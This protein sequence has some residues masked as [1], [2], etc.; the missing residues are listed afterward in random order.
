MV[1]GKQGFGE[2]QPHADVTA[3][4]TKSA[5]LQAFLVQH[6]LL[7]KS[8]SIQQIK[9]LCNAQHHDGS[10]STQGQPEVAALRQQLHGGGFS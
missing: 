10:L 6:S 8:G 5:R 4:T 1:K 3:V 2:A 7:A 9:E